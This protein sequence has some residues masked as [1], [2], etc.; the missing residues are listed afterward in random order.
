[1]TIVTKSHNMEAVAAA[2]V[3]Q[4]PVTVGELRVTPLHPFV[5]G[6]V[7]GLD[8]A[9]PVSDALIG[10]IE[11]AM[12]LFAVLV[13]P[14][15]QLDDQ[16]QFAFASR[17]GPIEAA[18]GGVKERGNRLAIKDMND[19]SN[20]GQD[21]TILP[22]GDRTRMYALGNLL[23]HSDSS[24][25]PAPASYSMLH[26]RVVPPEGGETEFAD[27]RAAWD[28]LPVR[29]KDTV[30]DLVCDHSIVTSRRKL[31]FE[32]FTADELKRGTPSPQRLVRRHER[33]G[34]LSLF[35]SAHIGGIHG[36]P[37][38]EALAL[39]NDL[40]EFATQRRFVYQHT[41][42]VHDLVIW[43]NRCTM[44]RGRRYDSHLYPRDLRRATVR[45]SGATVDESL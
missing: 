32:D 30:R 42:S 17:F 24:F 22:A 31:G 45:G 11:A 26:A 25:K 6:R 43:D 23:W 44:H 10:A 29:M 39:I 35:L 8:L 4:T 36:W 34:R 19:I 16:Q 20:L 41:W 37:V 5:G 9:A 3:A 40:T 38:P 33:S 12:D 14:G 7:D 18:A 27:M 13:I 21:G 1:M 15:Q 2:V 28:E